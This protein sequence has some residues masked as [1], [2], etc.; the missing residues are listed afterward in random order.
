MLI[1]S[2]TDRWTTEHRL[3]FSIGARVV[4]LFDGGAAFFCEAPIDALYATVELNESIL[5]SLM[6]GQSTGSGPTTDA[7]LKTCLDAYRDA[8]CP[9]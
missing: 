2:W 7:F 1:E 3:P 6:T 8:A 4:R 5:H 9:C